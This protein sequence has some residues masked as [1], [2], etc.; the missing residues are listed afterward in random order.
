MKSFSQF[1]QES[2]FYEVVAASNPNIATRRPG[3]STIDYAKR[4]SQQ[5]QQRMGQNTIV[6]SSTFNRT[7]AAAPEVTATNAA[8]SNPNTGTT[9]FKPAGTSSTPTQT[10]QPTRPQPSAA[11]PAATPVASSSALATRPQPSAIVPAATPVASS[12]VQPTR[13]QPSAAAPAAATK[14]P[15]LRGRV[16]RGG[17]GAL[18]AADAVDAARRGDVGGAVQSGL[19]AGASSNRLNKGTARLGQNAVKSVA[20]RLGAKGA[21][22]IAARFVPGLQTA[23]GVARGT[24]ALNRGDYLGAALGYGSALPVVGGAV[25]VADIAR[26][27]VDDP[28]ER[29]KRIAS[30]GVRSARQIGAQSGKFG[31]RYG[32]AISGS[33]G[34]TTVDKKAGTITSGGRT[35]KLGSTQ[36]ITDPRTGKKVVADLAYKGGKATYLARPSVASRDT[37]L[38]SR[39]SRWSGIGGQRAADAAAA[40]KEYR[41][42]LKNTQTYQKQIKG[43]K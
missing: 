20:A 31:A 18:S 43:K 2:Y 7:S 40:K 8:A 26:D 33:G 1:L 21:G 16:F 39:F 19:L 25:A 27:V 17:L 35:A 42:A 28:N 11:A 29:Y 36:L 3:E 38:A 32:S 24:S 30:S 5:T 9:P 37:N 34:P 6:P 23:Y 41:T 4:R 10:V 22:Q 12:R 14:R 15:T 13:P